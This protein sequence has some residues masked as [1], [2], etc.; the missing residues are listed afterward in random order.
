MGNV[1]VEN[2]SPFGEHE[3]AKKTLVDEQ[4]E[5]VVNRRPRHHGEA[6]FDSGP[7]FIGG[8]MVFGVQNVLSD[9]DTLRGWVNSMVPENRCLVLAHEN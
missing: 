1:G 3:R 8:G 9:R 7:H 4:I 2:D 5:S 6:R